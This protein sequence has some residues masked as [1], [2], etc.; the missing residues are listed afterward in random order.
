MIRTVLYNTDTQEVVSKIIDGG[1]QDTLPANIDELPVV[2]NAPPAIDEGVEYWTR[3]RDVVSG[4]WRWVY[5]VEQFTQQEIDDRYEALV[6]EIISNRALRL[7][8]MLEGISESDVDTWIETVSEVW[9]DI[10]VSSVVEIIESGQPTRWAISGVVSSATYA[11]TDIEV[12]YLFIDSAG[13]KYTVHSI[14]NSSDAN[15]IMNVE[16]IGDSASVVPATGNGVIEEGIREAIRSSWNGPDN[17][18]NE[19]WIQDFCTAE[20]LDIMELFLSV[21]RL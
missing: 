14:E 5:T 7:A 4:A 18:R 1:Y 17:T 13:N 19:Q 16:W 2:E 10:N 8:F 12:G 9:V 3:E 21:K 15:F 20:S 6:P 11:G